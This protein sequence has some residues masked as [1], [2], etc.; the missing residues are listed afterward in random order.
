MFPNLHFNENLKIILSPYNFLEN[1]NNQK[2]VKTT[3]TLQCYQS[4]G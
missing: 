1:R 2:L 4:L 3:K